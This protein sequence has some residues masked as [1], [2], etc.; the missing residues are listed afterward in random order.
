M[1]HLLAK[2]LVQILSEVAPVGLVVLEEAPVHSNRGGRHGR[3]CAIAAYLL[4]Q[5]CQAC[6]NH[7]CAPPCH[8]MA[9]LLHLRRVHTALTSCSLLPPEWASQQMRACTCPCHT[10]LP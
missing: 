3:V 1:D 6:R 8:H 5:A 10:P 2:H 7:G 4:Q 9:H